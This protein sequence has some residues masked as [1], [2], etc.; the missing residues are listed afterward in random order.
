[1]S[2][3][4]AKAN[5]NGVAAHPFKFPISSR[6]E[7]EVSQLDVWSIFS[8][9][10]GYVPKDS[11]N[12]GQGFMNWLPPP[13]VREKAKE[14]LE[15]VEANHYS[16]PMGRIRLRKALAEY[17]SESFGR[18]LDETKEILVTAGA[19]NGIYAVECAF[20]QPGDEVIMFE[21]YFD[22]YIC[23]TTFNQGVP[24]FVPLHPPP[25]ASKETVS[26]REWKIDPDELRRAITPK[27][28]FI[29][30]NTPHNPIGK[31]FTEEEL[32]QIGDIAEEHN[33]LIMSDEVYDC[34]ALN[35][36]QHVRIAALKNFWDRT[37]TIG[38]AG[39]SFSSTG[40]R[41]GWAVG[42][43]HL[44]RPTLAAST[45]IVFVTN[46]PLQEAVAGALEE[47][48]GRGFWDQQRKEYEERL[49]V[50]REALDKLGLPYTVPEG[51]YFVL[52]NVERLKIPDDFVVPDMLAPFAHDFKA[53]WFVS[54][55][56]K[57]VSIPVSAFFDKSHWS[58]GEKYLR[59]AFCKDLKTL[60]EAGERLQVLK[61]YI[62]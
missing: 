34:L 2:S 15:V 51:S 19:N 48:S 8:P 45:R 43:S 47:A 29:F 10:S 40:W 3:S 55:T 52:V 57:V 35:G 27:T 14:A 36:S 53:A 6:I 5:A 37:I 24:V 18:R 23:N 13:F 20:L 28:K 50:L 11:L 42:P 41:V 12:L 56:A 38:S 25:N 22:Q 32:I 58:I 59:F 33:L 9:A 31:V 26:S 16:H 30:L 39:K 1:M 17:L 7:R 21:P 49:E 4:T 46:S 60:R 44:I 62:V 61:Q 54:E